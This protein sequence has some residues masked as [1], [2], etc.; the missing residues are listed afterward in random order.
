MGVGDAGDESTGAGS[1]SGSA[2]NPS[3]TG[4][5]PGGESVGVT[6]NPD[7]ISTTVGSATDPSTDPTTDP[8]DTG[9][10]STSGNPFLIDPDGGVGG[11]PCSIWDQDCPKGEACRAWA[12]DGGPLWNFLR[13]SPVAEMPDGIDEPCV[14]EGGPVSGVDSCG[15]GAQCVNVDPATLEG[16]CAQFCDGEPANPICPNP[17]DTCIEGNDGWVALCLRQCDPLLQDCGGDEIC[18]GSWNEAD[19]FCARQDLPY[20]DA[21]GVQVAACGIG[22]VAVPPELV[23]GCDDDIPCCT[24]FCDLETADPLCPKGLQCESFVEEG[25]FP[26]Q[27]FVGAC[28]SP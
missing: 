19:F 25:S 17:E 15:V 23:D 9:A 26:G 6:T 14:V 28:L 2:P 27:F 3:T 16:T 1:T 12:N 8:D 24:D 11:D 10:E 20:E 13:C 4:P 22:R 21:V 5:R 7:P 18:V